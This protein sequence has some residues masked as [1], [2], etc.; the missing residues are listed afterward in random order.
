MNAFLAR[1]TKV[2]DD[3]ERNTNRLKFVIQFT[4]K[5]VVEDATA[6]PVAA[7]DQ[8]EVGEEILVFELETVFGFCYMYQKMKTEDNTRLRVGNSLIDIQ[9]DCIDIEC[10]GGNTISI[11][12]DGD[13]TISTNGGLQ[14]DI[15]GDADISVG[16]NCA[17]KAA[18]VE[19]PQ[20]GS[21][22]PTG[23][24]PFC[25]IKTCPYTGL[26]HTGYKLM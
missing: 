19:M 25:A 7:F 13:L 21:V 16:G 8:P 10:K 4:A 1:V 24:G 23:T 17:I 2:K 5:G 18:S 26:P 9:P 20:S 3:A 6:Y 11:S 14:V 15:K 22:A 12:S